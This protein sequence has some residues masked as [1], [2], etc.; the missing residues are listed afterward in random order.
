MQR[1]HRPQWSVRSSK[2]KKPTWTL[3]GHRRTDTEIDAWS[4]GVAEELRSVPKTVLGSRRSSLLT[5]SESYDAP[6]LQC[7]REIFARVQPRIALQ[8]ELLEEGHL[9]RDNGYAG[10]TTRE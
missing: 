5:S 9:I 7:E 6:S 1:K 10:S 4:C 2:W 3:S 8:E